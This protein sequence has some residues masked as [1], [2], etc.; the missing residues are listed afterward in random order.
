MDQSIKAIHEKVR[1]ASVFAQALKQEIS[2]F[3]RRPDIS[4]DVEVIV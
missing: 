2:K 3:K 4:F 1:Q